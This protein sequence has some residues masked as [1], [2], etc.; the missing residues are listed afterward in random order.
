M[1]SAA[2]FSALAALLIGSAVAQQR[3][4]VSQGVTVQVTAVYS[5]KTPETRKLS[6]LT[7]DAGSGP[8][9]FTC[10]DGKVTHQFQRAGR[11]L[12]IQSTF[13]TLTFSSGGVSLEQ[14]EQ[15]LP[16]QADQVRIWCK[17]N[18]PQLRTGSLIETVTPEDST[19]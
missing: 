19:P 18:A 15:A 10:V 16:L 8:K 3:V 6:G 9:T 17:D 4:P 7:L 11:K 13:L 12:N 5:G 2:R 14:S 1:S